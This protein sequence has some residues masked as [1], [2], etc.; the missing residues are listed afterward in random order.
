M[1]IERPMFYSYLNTMAFLP[2][3]GLAIFIQTS[4]IAV[5]STVRCSICEICERAVFIWLVNVIPGMIRIKV[6]S[7]SDCLP[8]FSFVAQVRTLVSPSTGEHT[9]GLTGS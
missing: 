5:I 9:P 3:D 7:P 8:Y 6:Y 4:C 1:A 2:S